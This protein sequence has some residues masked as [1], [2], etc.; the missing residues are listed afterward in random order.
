MLQDYVVEQDTTP[1]DFILENMLRGIVAS[2]DSVP[3]RIVVILL[4]WRCVLCL[5]QLAHL[6]LTNALFGLREA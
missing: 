6:S 2:G 5:A 1:C 4:R 3:L